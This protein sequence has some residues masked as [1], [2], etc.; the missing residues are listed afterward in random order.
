MPF[1]PIQVR[2]SVIDIETVVEV[3]DMLDRETAADSPASF[4][5]WG[6]VPRTISR[7]ELEALGAP[8][9]ARLT[10]NKLLPTSDGGVQNAEILFVRRHEAMVNMPAGYESL[11]DRIGAHIVESG[12]PR[13]HQRT[14]L[15]GLPIAFAATFLG[16]WI[17]TE[18]TVTM[19]VPF[20]YLGWLTVLGA[21]GAAV[22]AV[23]SIRRAFRR[24]LGHR[25]RN[26]SRATTY[27]R[28]ADSWANVRVAFWT[29]LITVGVGALAG[30]LRLPGQ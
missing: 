3:A 28:R 23:R 29:V 26:E 16:F 20:H 14:W 2:P 30:I 6:A 5:I 1:E 11:R 10:V 27:A 22:L 9:R 4:R 18:A 8:E 12:R 19:A 25:I 17:W 7:H 21:M 15:S 24:P 13:L